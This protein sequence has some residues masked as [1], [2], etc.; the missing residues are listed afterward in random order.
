MCLV[1]VPNVWPKACAD[2]TMQISWVLLASHKS[3][4]NPLI[5]LIREE[6]WGDSNSCSLCD[7]PLPIP[8]NLNHLTDIQLVDPS[9]GHP[10]KNVSINLFVEVLLHDWRIGLSAGSLLEGLKPS[11][12]W[13]K[14]PP[15]MPLSSLEIK[16]YAVSGGS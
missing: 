14:L 15:S 3:P 2:I 9:F 12:Q 8:F 16:S 6:S 7:L 10:G 11:R 4:I 5:H 1:D 13:L